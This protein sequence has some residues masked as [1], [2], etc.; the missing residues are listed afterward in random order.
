MAGVIVL[1]VALAYCSLE[2][3]RGQDFV[4]PDTVSVQCGN[5]TL[6]GLLW[7]R[8]YGSFSS[9]DIQSWQLCKQK[10]LRDDI[11]GLC[12]MTSSAV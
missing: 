11:L 6:T 8:R 10:Y 9:L 5:L 7:S 1:A 12:P 4:G 2:N 3:L